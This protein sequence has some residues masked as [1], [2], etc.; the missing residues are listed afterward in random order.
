MSRELKDNSSVVS[1]DFDI[2]D[3]VVNDVEERKREDEKFFDTEDVKEKESSKSFSMTNEKIE[4]NVCS[5][6][7]V[8]SRQSDRIDEESTTSTIIPRYARSPMD[9]FDGFGGGSE[10][11]RIY[12][13][14]VRD[15][16]DSIV[17]NSNSNNNDNYK[18]GKNKIDDN[19]KPVFVYV[20]DHDGP[21]SSADDLKTKDE[22][23]RI[24]DPLISNEEKQNS[25]ALENITTKGKVCLR[26][27]D[28]NSTENKMENVTEKYGSYV[29]EHH[30]P[31]DEEE[32]NDPSGKD[33]GT[34][35]SLYKSK[36]EKKEGFNGKDETEEKHKDAEER[37]DDADKHE[38]TDKYE[39]AEENHEDTGRKQENAEDAKENE[40]KHEGTD[41]KHEDVDSKDDD[42]DK[43]H[44]DADGKHEDTDKIHEDA[45]GKHDD[46]DSKDE[47]TDGKH[48]DTD[49]IHEDADG[50]HDDTDSKDE[51][52][53]GEHDDTDKIHKDAD[54]KHENG[55]EIHEDTDGKHDNADEKHDDT[56]DGNDKQEGEAKRKKEAA[57]LDEIMQDLQGE[58]EDENIQQQEGTEA[59][60]NDE[61][62]NESSKEEESENTEEK[63]SSETEKKESVIKPKKK[64]VIFKREGDTFD[65]KGDRRYDMSALEM[66]S[67]DES[68]FVNLQ[69]VQ[70]ARVELEQYAKNLDNF[71][72]IISELEKTPE[73]KRVQQDEPKSISFRLDELL[74]DTDGAEEVKTPKSAKKY[75]KKRTKKKKKKNEEGKL[76]QRCRQPVFKEDSYL[77][78]NAIFNGKVLCKICSNKK[79]RVQNASAPKNQEDNRRNRTEVKPALDSRLQ[80]SENRVLKKWLEQKNKEERKKKRE[81]RREHKLK[82]KENKEKKKQEAERQEKAKQQVADWEERKRKEAKQQKKKNISPFFKLNSRPIVHSLGSTTTAVS[83]TT[84]A[85]ESPRSDATFDIRD[86]NSFERFHEEIF[87]GKPTPPPLLELTYSSVADFTQSVILSAILEIEKERQRNYPKQL[88]I[89]R[90]RSHAPSLKQHNN[91]NRQQLQPRPPPKSANPRNKRTRRMDQNSSGHTVINDP[92]K[93]T[94]LMRAK[95]YDEWLTDK[96]TQRGLKEKEREINQHYDLLQ[97]KLIELEKDRRK[98]LVEIRQTSMSTFQDN[99]LP[100]LSNAIITTN[101]P[102]RKLIM[103][104]N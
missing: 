9:Q 16:F 104:K 65:D 57:I 72:H 78:S 68:E 24:R 97:Q 61:H 70:Q 48:E 89:N 26:K 95:T 45:D 42:T 82:V 7:A 86:D 29:N 33:N 88:T 103:T 60:K 62:S 28:E 51:D 11:I 43:I 2:F 39:D 35:V 91:K 67:E 69:E 25:S 54:G 38:D 80:S 58:T 90:P 56:D 34:I 30:A 96:Q 59:A 101:E 102:S 10:S 22:K 81:E 79:R 85:N 53:D 64:E 44:E 63:N 71:N 37:Y 4:I 6:P 50:K 18:G 92:M 3:Q 31:D 47:D 87:G 66:V 100:K 94:S 83:N 27:G 15:S 17:V 32:G 1:E 41:E 40:I 73:E 49:K 23:D 74:V 52:T 12:T 93:R 20:E 98:T 76:C 77:E 84:S 5:S 36:E 99:T 46:T 8:S 55:D 14:D 21:K 75:P 19:K 13:P